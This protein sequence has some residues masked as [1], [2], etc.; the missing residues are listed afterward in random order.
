M[1]KK[2]LFSLSVQVNKI[3]SEIDHH[4]SPGARCWQEDGLTWYEWSYDPTKQLTVSVS[5]TKP[6]DTESHLI[7][8]NLKAG[9]IKIDQIEQTGTYRRSDTG[10][11][12]RNVHGYMSWPGTYTFKIRYSPQI[13]N[14]ITYLAKLAAK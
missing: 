12:V 10:Q 6:P 11:V 2:L 3:D 8:S 1:T 9:G 13:H 7:I 14:Y 4:V 5:M